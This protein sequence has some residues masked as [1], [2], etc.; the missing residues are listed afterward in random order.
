ML[1]NPLHYRLQVKIAHFIRFG[2]FDVLF[3]VFLFDAHRVAF[4]MFA[5]APTTLLQGW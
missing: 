5:F 2:V 1:C 3:L 4:I